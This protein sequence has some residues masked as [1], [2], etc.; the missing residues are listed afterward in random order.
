MTCFTLSK[1]ARNCNRMD[2]TALSLGSIVFKDMLS[3][4]ETVS[5]LC[6]ISVLQ[7]EDAAFTVTEDSLDLRQL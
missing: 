1:K 7:G 6:D 2:I 5:Q 3:V 4:F